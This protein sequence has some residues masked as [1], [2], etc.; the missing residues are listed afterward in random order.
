MQVLSSAVGGISGPL[1]F[2][3]LGEGLGYPHVYTIDAVVVFIVAEAYG[4]L[5]FHR[6]RRD[7]PPACCGRR[8]TIEEETGRVEPNAGLLAADH[9]KAGRK[10]GQS[11]VDY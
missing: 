8:N 1:L 11:S 7:H 6:F 4:L 5:L 3:G 9:S 2:A 10:D